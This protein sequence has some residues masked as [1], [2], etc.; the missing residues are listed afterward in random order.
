ML[1]LD[2]KTLT[3]VNAF[4]IEV[5]LPK[6]YLLLLFNNIFVIRKDKRI[7]LHDSNTLQCFEVTKHIS[8]SRVGLVYLVKK[9][10][11]HIEK[12]KKQSTNSID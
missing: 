5:V 11:K 4:N 12:T 2:V 6:S 9:N 7:E 8:N 10:L 3:I 1:T